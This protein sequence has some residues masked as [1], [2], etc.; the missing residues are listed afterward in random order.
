MKYPKESPDID[1]ESHI[2]QKFCPHCKKWKDLEKDFNRDRVRSRD[3]R[4]AICK[5]CRK[6][7]YA[8]Q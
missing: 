1:D 3:G 4:S 7:K 2:G 5:L 8:L 6:E